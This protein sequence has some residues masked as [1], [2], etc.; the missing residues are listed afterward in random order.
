M[1]YK[2]SWEFF[3]LLWFRLN[4]FN[5]K[6]AVSHNPINI[7]LGFTLSDLFDNLYDIFILKFMFLTGKGNRNAFQ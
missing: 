5:M 6:Y 1:R 4:C 3:Y 2:S 7:G